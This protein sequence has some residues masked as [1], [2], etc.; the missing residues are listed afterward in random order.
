MTGK[1]RAWRAGVAIWPR[2]NTGREEIFMIRMLMRGTALAAALT[3]LNLGTAANAQIAVSANDNKIA[4]VD[5]ANT[6]PANPPPDTVTILDIGVSPPKV[7]GELQAPSS[8]VGVPQSV[9]VS[10][11]ETFAIVTSAMKVDAADP[12][13]TAPDDRVSVIDLKANPPAV[14][15]TL[16]AGAGVT[17]VSISPS[18]TLAITA[19]RAEGTLSLFTISGKTLSPAGKID[20]GNKASGPSH[21]A[22]LPDGKS[23]IVTRDGDHRVSILSIDGN[24]VEDT[25]KFMVGGFRPYSLVVSPKGDVAVFGNQGGGQGDSDQINVVDLKSNP[26]R[27]VEAI[28]V[29]QTPEGVSMA[30]DGSHVA[31]ILHN[32]SPRKNNHPAYNDHGLMRIFKVDGTKL[33]LVTTTKIG[34]WAQGSVWSRDGKTIV[35]QAT[36]EKE[37]QVFS[38]DGKEAKLTGA[39]KTNGGGVGMRTSMQ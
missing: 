11:D 12:K 30:P 23:A 16:Q 34:T 33:T 19:N 8:V 39:V 4:L 29:G 6:V 38:F 5:G 37:L 27:V 1:A 18:G 10:K 14:T 26:P 15:Q 21:V 22:F 36:H 20:L 9:A 25:K 32:G 28:S 31:V 2:E 3:A 35:V 13:K 17:G 24:K 7:L